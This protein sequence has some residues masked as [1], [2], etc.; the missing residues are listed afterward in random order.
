MSSPYPAAFSHLPVLTPA[1][2]LARGFSSLSP[3]PFLCA[4]RDAKTSR[5]GPDR[6]RGVRANASFLPP[7]KLP[8]AFGRGA[9][10]QD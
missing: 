1:G 5:E 4:D 8:L 2:Q 9:F 10:Q 7:V 6:R 3:A